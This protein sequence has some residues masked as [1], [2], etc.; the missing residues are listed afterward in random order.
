MD[1]LLIKNLEV[2]DLIAMPYYGSAITLGV[3]AGYGT[4]KNIKYYP[5]KGKITLHPLLG[6]LHSEKSYL[7]KA[8]RIYPSDIP[9]KELV[10]EY[11]TRIKE[12]ITLGI[13]PDNYIPKDVTH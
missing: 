3:F 5:L 6:Y 1:S 8:V 10:N 12:L 7:R 4:R 2:G 9:D 11:H 13:L